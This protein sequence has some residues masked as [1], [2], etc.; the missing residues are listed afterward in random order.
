[1]EEARLIENINVPVIYC[2]TFASVTIE[3]ENVRIVFVEYRYVAGERVRSP[4]LEMI[5]PAKSCAGMLVH[6]IAAEQRMRR[7]PRTEH[8]EVH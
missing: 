3:G 7:Y 5:R 8:L 2:D 4:V 6:V 1:M